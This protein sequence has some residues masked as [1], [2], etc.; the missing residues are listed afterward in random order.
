MMCERC[1]GFMTKE[2][3]TDHQTTG[4]DG[5]SVGFRCVLCGDVVDALILQNRRR[6]RALGQPMTEG[7]APRPY[8]P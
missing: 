1:G 7:R 4:G 3:L 6:A 8:I 5:A 2:C